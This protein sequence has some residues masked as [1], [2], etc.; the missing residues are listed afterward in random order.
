MKKSHWG[1]KYIL[2]KK[3]IHKIL[4]YLSY[5]QSIDKKI[6]FL[7]LVLIDKNNLVQYFIKAVM[8]CILV[9]SECLFIYISAIFNI[10][11]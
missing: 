10:Q 8:H 11:E 4:R 3:V 2:C 9:K 7:L 5:A 6:D 1:S